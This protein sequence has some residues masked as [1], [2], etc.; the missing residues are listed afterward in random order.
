M[1]PAPDVEAPWVV[2]TTADKC[3]QCLRALEGD[4]SERILLTIEDERGRALVA[5]FC[6]IDC[7]MAWRATRE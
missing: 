3:H 6:N 4:E 5:E 2:A 7:Y 1:F